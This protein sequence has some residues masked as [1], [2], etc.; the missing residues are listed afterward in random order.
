MDILAEIK[1]KRVVDEMF[2]THPHLHNHVML[3]ETFLAVMDSL[4]ERGMTEAMEW[5]NKNKSEIVGDPIDRIGNIES[6]PYLHRVND[7]V[8][9]WIQP[10]LFGSH[11]VMVGPIV[12]AKIGCDSWADYRDLESA[13][14]ASKVW[15][16]Y[17]D[18]PK[19]GL[20]RYQIAYANGIGKI[21][22]VKHEA[23]E[24]ASH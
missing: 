11:K 2:G 4:E 7:W 1:F 12:D 21:Q 18:P 6:F 23:D 20:I 22:K 19:E 17:N 24:E 10:L 9:A 13:E 16:G 15:G 3:E 8:I 14:R 5:A